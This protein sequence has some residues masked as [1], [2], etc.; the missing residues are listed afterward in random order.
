MNTSFNI[1]APRF[2]AI[3]LMLQDMDTGDLYEGGRS[4]SNKRKRSDYDDDYSD[5]DSG[6][7][8]DPNA[9]DSSAARF[10]TNLIRAEFNKR[11]GDAGSPKLLAEPSKEDMLLA[12][13]TALTDPLTKKIPNLTLKARE[14]WFKKIQQVLKENFDLFVHRMSSV[15]FEFDQTKM[16]VEFE[17]DQVKKSK[18]LSI[19]QANC[20]KKIKELK[21]YT[22]ENKFYLEEY[23]RITEAINTNKTEAVDDDVNR[24][25]FDA[26]ESSGITTARLNDD[27]TK[28]DGF[29]M[30][31]FTSALSVFNN[32]EKSYLDEY[33]KKPKKEDEFREDDK[34][35]TVKSEKFV[36]KTEPTSYNEMLV[37]NTTNI[38]EKQVDSVKAE[39]RE[40][41]EFQYDNSKEKKMSTLLKEK[42][43]VDVKKEVNN[44]LYLTLSTL[45]NIVVKELTV[46]YKAGKI[47]NKV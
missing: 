23:K 45:S 40:A 44:K 41:N 13:T 2:G 37:N 17:Y 33:S 21:G 10:R 28:F 43:S 20:I 15:D 36:F 4:S 1:K 24:D 47:I 34:N 27:S 6:R 29:K 19:Y 7:S 22:N 30:S 25:N 8:S 38:D 14:N 11:K 31:G 16:C 26:S 46:L 18:N 35:L 39:P 32:V 3:G 12:E 9:Y 42:V 5:D